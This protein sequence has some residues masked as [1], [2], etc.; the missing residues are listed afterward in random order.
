MVPSATALALC[1]ALLLA[2]LTHGESPVP[3]FIS[4]PAGG[5]LSL[6]RLR[7]GSLG[8]GG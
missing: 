2:R 3:V 1:L 5:G 6:S 7:A 8:W 4:P